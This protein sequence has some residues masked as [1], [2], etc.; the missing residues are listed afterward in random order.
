M[1]K[2]SNGVGGEKEIPLRPPPAPVAK[3]QPKQPPR[4]TGVITDSARQGIITD[5]WTRFE[6]LEAA[7]IADDW[8]QVD[9]EINSLSIQLGIV[10]HL[11]ENI[12]KVSL[13]HVC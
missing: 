7:L 1:G 12:R 3:E 9:A 5:L 2:K 10:R 8:P 6:N 13:C 11:A 4:G